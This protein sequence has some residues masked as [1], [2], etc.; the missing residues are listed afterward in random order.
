MLIKALNDA[1]K[2]H[3]T[4]VIFMDKPNA[5]KHSGRHMPSRTIS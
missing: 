3:F 1:F 2:G 4:N 5:M